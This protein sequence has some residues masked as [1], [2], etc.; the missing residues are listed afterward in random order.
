MCPRPPLNIVW[1]I[2]SQ[3]RPQ[4]ALRTHVNT[5]SEQTLN[6]QTLVTY[7]RRNELTIM[8]PSM[9]EGTVYQFTEIQT[10]QLNSNNWKQAYSISDF[11]KLVHVSSNCN[12]ALCCWLGFSS[13]L[14]LCSVRGS[15]VSVLKHSCTS[16]CIH[17]WNTI[18]YIT[19]HRAGESWIVM[20]QAFFLCSHHSL[21]PSL[22]LYFSTG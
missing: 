10:T 20:L 17:Y 7:E 2:G 16:W 4:C 1:V 15:S 3:M 18:G 12:K 14:L 13:K 21:S 22:T 6:H 5:R 11:R 8:S 9:L 19:M